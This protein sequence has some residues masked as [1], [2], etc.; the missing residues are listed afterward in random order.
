MTIPRKGENNGEQ[1]LKIKVLHQ[2]TSDHI[3]NCQSLN[4]KAIL[5]AS[6]F[7]F[8]STN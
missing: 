7:Q 6:K 1:V 8:S 5:N 2:L 4:I 3:S